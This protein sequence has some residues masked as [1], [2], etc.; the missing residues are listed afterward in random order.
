MSEDPIDAMRSEILETGGRWEW[1]PFAVTVTRGDEW[2]G[3][4][5]AG[6]LDLATTPRLELRLG[7]LDQ[8]RPRTILVDLAGVTFI[9]L[10]GVR[11]L[12]AAQERAQAH[13]YELAIVRESHAA[14]R[15]FALIGADARLNL[16]D[17]PAPGQPRR[18]PIV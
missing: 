8:E 6:E 16:I 14:R 10:T 12:L 1:P 5:V 7:R 3:L 9:D 2:R 15:L 4:V 18:M 13:G 11:A 17:D